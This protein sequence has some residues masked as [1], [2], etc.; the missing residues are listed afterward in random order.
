[1]KAETLG[2][3]FR[4]SFGSKRGATRDASPDRNQLPFALDSID[5]GD[6]IARQGDRRG[7]EPRALRPSHPQTEAR[8]TPILRAIDKSCPQRISL[9]VAEHRE[10]MLVALDRKGLEAALP[11]MPAA[12]VVPMI[13][14]DVAGEQS[15][16]PTAE[17]AVAVRPEDEMEMVGHEAPAEDSH[18]QALA[19]GL[20]QPQKGPEIFL[21]V[22]D[23]SARVAKVEH[24][25]APIGTDSSG[26]SR[27]ER[28]LP[29]RPE[30]HE[31]K[32]ECPFF[33]L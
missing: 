10:Q 27:R 31:K 17:V 9:G 16:H 1:L 19:S 26:G 14:A 32:V 8:P 22:K 11:D 7:S 33:A 5:P 2:R 6:P 13:A 28:I 24:M 3:E 30:Q 12:V 20:E 23:F 21:L 15:L 4:P 25:I 18:R 29:R